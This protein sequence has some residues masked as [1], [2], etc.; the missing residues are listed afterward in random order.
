MSITYISKEYNI[1]KLYQCKTKNTMLKRMKPMYFIYIYI[2]IILIV[3][4]FFIMPH[5]ENDG[6][7]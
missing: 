5:L 7:I 4:I 3:L 2:F 6:Y 1:N